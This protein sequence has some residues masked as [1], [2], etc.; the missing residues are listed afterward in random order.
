[1]V[2]KVESRLLFQQDGEMI[3]GV[4]LQRLMK[5]CEDKFGITSSG[6]HPIHLCNFIIFPQHN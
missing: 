2:G 1:M 5:S 6:F 3:L 4:M